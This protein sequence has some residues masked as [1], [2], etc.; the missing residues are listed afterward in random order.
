MS[1]IAKAIAYGMEAFINLFID[2]FYPRKVRFPHHMI[3][4]PYVK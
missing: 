4:N 1:S 2:L 3:V